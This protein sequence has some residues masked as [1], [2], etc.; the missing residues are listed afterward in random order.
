MLV[1]VM[2]I[3]LPTETTWSITDIQ[4]EIVI[5]VWGTKYLKTST[6]KKKKKFKRAKLKTQLWTSAE[7]TWK[8]LG[9]SNLNRCNAALFD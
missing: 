6:K 4:G 9:A 5:N 7:Q 8:S 3:G 2:Y 1:L